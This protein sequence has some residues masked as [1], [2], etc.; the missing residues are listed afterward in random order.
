MNPAFAVI[1]LGVIIIGFL[2]FTTRFFDNSIDS[3]TLQDIQDFRVSIQ[4][5]NNEHIREYVT[6]T[7]KKTDI[8]QIIEKTKYLM[9]KPKQKSESEKIP[10]K[11]VKESGKKEFGIIWKILSHNPLYLSLIWTICLVLIF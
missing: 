4:R 3:V 6:E 11:E 2:T 9:I 1:V 8:Q 5:W 10:W 7:I